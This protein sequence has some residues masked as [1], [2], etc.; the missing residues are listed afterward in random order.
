[1]FFATAPIPASTILRRPVY[2]PTART[3][4]RFLDDALVTARQQACAYAQDETSY[5]LS[6]DLPGIA[7]EDLTIAIEG[8]VVRIQ[9]KETAQRKYR[10]AYELPQEI[11]SASS[12][13]RLENG[14]LQLKL[15]KKVPVS[16]ATELT[17]Q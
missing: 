10:A 4:E 9:S 6:L 5:T 13:A 8:A 12:Q 16:N 1:M 2:N 7:R 3:V 15:V 17:I 14:V 11:D